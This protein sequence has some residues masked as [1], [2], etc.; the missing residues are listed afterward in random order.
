[1]RA[2][3]GAMRTP[4]VVTW[5][6]FPDG[7]KAFDLEVTSGARRWCVLAVPGAP[8]AEDRGLVVF[9]VQDHSKL[10]PGRVIYLRGDDLQKLI[11][12]LTTLKGTLDV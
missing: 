1:V 7:R 8:T 5:S 2:G 12:A 9:A 6:S 4:A 11:D 3:E 10:E